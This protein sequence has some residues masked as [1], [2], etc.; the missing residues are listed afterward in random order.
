[1][2]GVD[3]LFVDGEDYGV[4][5]DD[6]PDNVIGA[7]YF[8]R[9][10]PPD[11]RPWFGVVWDMVAD[12]DQRFLQE[13]FSVEH[14]PEVVQRVWAKARELG[15]G[16]IFVD[17]TMRGITDDHLP[18]QAAGI[19]IIDVIDCCADSYVYWHTTQDTPDKV[20][21]QALANVGKLAVALVR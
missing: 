7:R 14:A 13:G 3:L 4:F 17:R 18:L 6:Y 19:R 21:P 20:S 10:L 11:Y 1:M 5:V 16:A 15:L 8:A 2:V 12:Y 9:H